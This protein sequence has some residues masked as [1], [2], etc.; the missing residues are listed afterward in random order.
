MK[1]KIVLLVFLLISVG[2]F[3]QKNMGYGGGFQYEVFDPFGEDDP[4][5]LV[6]I[7]GEIAYDLQRRKAS[8]SPFVRPSLMAG[9]MVGEHH[10]YWRIG[11]FN[12]TAQFLVGVRLGMLSLSVG[13]GAGYQTY[14]ALDLCG[15]DPPEILKRPTLPTKWLTNV[16]FYLDKRK[17]LYVYGEANTPT[18]GFNFQVVPEIGARLG[19]MYFIRR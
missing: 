7:G 9:Y 16:G 15:C 12:I 5:E 13:A 19:F 2:M 3:A 18:P 14:S 1:K 17:T 11:R 8:V 10:D 6:G 4:V